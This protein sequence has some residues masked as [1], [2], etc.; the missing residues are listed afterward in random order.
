MRTALIATLLGLTLPTAALAAS[1]TGAQA[2]KAYE[3]G[4]AGAAP[5]NGY[6]YASCAGYWTGWTKYS[7]ENYQD[8]L[9]SALPD[10]MKSSGALKNQLYWQEKTVAEVKAGRI[11]GAQAQS[12]LVTSKAL[13]ETSIAEDSETAMTRMFGELGRCHVER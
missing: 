11:P 7:L 8:P 3:S 13:V 9:V 10:G 2:V 4:K 5:Q 12:M 6:D 1:I